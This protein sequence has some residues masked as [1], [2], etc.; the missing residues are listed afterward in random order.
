[1][2]LIF[3]SG[4]RISNILYSITTYLPQDKL[5]FV[6]DTSNILNLSG[7]RMNLCFRAILNSLMRVQYPKTYRVYNFLKKFKD[8]QMNIQFTDLDVA[9]AIYLTEMLSR[10]KKVTDLEDTIRTNFSIDARI[11][12]VCDEILPITVKSSVKTMFYSEYLHTNATDFKIQ[13]INFNGIE[14][15]KPNENLKKVANKSEYILLL[16]NDLVAFHAMLQVPGVRK[17]LE[18]VSCPIFAI[19][20]IIDRSYLST[21]ETNILNKLGYLDINAVEFSKTVENLVDI[22][23]IDETQKIYKEQIMNAGFQV[24]V[25]DLKIKNKKDAF[26]LAT[27]LFNLFPLK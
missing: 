22:I 21:E 25:R 18:D 2:L 3:Y 14:T 10:G 20:P 16:P 19:F 8:T 4:T 24:Y 11:I 9:I 1:M 7:I 12:P 13:E 26:E 17:I 15:K 23:I 6:I 5:G 27:F